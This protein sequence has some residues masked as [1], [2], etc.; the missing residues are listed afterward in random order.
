MQKRTLEELINTVGPAWPLVQE[1]IATARNT[2]EVLPA[3]RRRG[4]NVLHYLQ[5]TTHSPSG[6]VALETGGMLIDH[7]WLR[8]L[9][10]GHEHMRGNLFSWNT[11]GAILESYLLKDACLVA[12]DAIADFLALNGGTFAG[13][14]G[15][16]F[17]FAPDNLRWKN[18]H[19]SYSQL[20]QWALDRDIALFYQGMH[21]PDWESDISFLSGDRGISIF[22][23]LCTEPEIPV[24]ERFRRAV[25]MYELWHLHLDLAQQLVRLPNGASGLCGQFFSCYRGESPT[26]ERGGR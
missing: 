13:E 21:W 14:L 7:G 15:K 9:V 10:S 4:E 3:D 1:W 6:A 17:Y 18:T 19:L 23:L 11:S 5:V 2:G 25:P 8:Y 26:F 24:S 20:L 16:A 12:Y 22:P